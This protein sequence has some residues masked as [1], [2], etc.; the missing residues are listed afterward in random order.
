[1]I[2]TTLAQKALIIVR[3]GFFVLGMFFFV[4]GLI[5]TMIFNSEFSPGRTFGLLFADAEARCTI[6]LVES[7][8]AYVNDRLVLRYAYKFNTVEDPSKT[9]YAEA[10]STKEYLPG[11]QVDV[12]YQSGNPDI[13]LPNGM[14]ASVM[15]WIGLLTLI[16]P[17]AGLALGLP[18][19]VR[20]IR[21]IGILQRGEI[22]RG[23]LL[24]SIPTGVRINNALVMRLTFEFLDAYGRT[25][26]AETKTHETNSLTD[27]PDELLVYNPRHPENAVLVDALPSFVRE[28]VEDL[29]EAQQAKRKRSE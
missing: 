15:G 20:G 24:S 5:I 13:S 22:A 2:P 27:E 9:Y 12:V 11:Q 3:S 7:T 19:L 28:I 16:F 26:H 1:M 6:Q 25:H 10:Y 4:I 8:H 29:E 18:G 14:D 17:S 21:N 23:K